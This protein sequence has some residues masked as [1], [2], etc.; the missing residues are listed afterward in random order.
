MIITIKGADFSTK[1]IGTLSTWTIFTSLGS[2]ATYSGSRAVDKDS[3]LSATITIAD[4]Y[5]LGSAGVSVIMGTIDV[6][7]SAATVN[8]NTI[9][10]NITAVTGNVTIKVP[11]LNTSTGEESGD[12]GVE[13]KSWDITFVA[14]KTI[15]DSTGALSTGS[16][17]VS[18]I[19]PTDNSMKVTVYSCKYIIYAYSDVAAS[20]PIG[21][22]SNDMSKIH[23]TQV[24]SAYRW[25][26]AGTI[27]ALTDLLALNA[28]IKSIRLMTYDNI[29]TP[30]YSVTSTLA[31]TSHNNTGSGSGSSVGVADGWELGTISGQTGALSTS[32]GRVRTPDYLIVDN[33]TS[34]SVSNV[35]FIIACY[36]SS[37]LY[38]GKYKEN[39][40]NTSV[41]WNTAGTIVT[42]AQIKSANSNVAKIKLVGYAINANSP[43]I[44]Q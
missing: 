28:N 42:M 39:V 8:G 24:T 13:T 33:I 40:I 11:T 6:T 21:F 35:D 44:V 15:S 2:G 43:T 34:V 17:G 32:T 26:E 4:G 29:A 1:N 27:R 25:H 41:E 23:P 38:L 20:V 14:S 19:I 18:E 31:D 3:S 16:R 12:T 10:I 22:V 37:N 9:T 30:T 7:S 5:E 36:D